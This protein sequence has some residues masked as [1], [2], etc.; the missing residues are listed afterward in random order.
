[1]STTETAEQAAGIG[2]DDAGEPAL[3]PFP[4][5]GLLP[6]LPAPPELR[7]L[8]TEQ[9]NDVVAEMRTRRGPV[10]TDIDTWPLVRMVKAFVDQV[11]AY[12][13]ALSAVSASALDVLGE[14]LVE[15]HGEQDG[16]PNGRLDVPCGELVIS[17]RPRRENRHDIDAGQVLSALAVLMTIQWGS[18]PDA[19]TPEDEPVLFAIEVA[20]RAV[21]MMGAAEL[22]VTRVRALAAELQL[23]DE[24]DMADVVRTAIHTSRLYKGIAVTDAP[25]E[26]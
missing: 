1:M 8:L 17:V 24:V 13:R 14:E 16:I 12:A 25:V 3:V 19:P 10:H 9:L 6:A 23:R 5:K 22:K 4:L 7:R 26:R 11:D 15:V 20:R 21:E 2:V 18:T